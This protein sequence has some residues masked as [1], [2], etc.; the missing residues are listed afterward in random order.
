MASQT[1]L[2]I[3][4]EGSHPLQIILRERIRRLSFAKWGTWDYVW[5]VNP[6]RVARTNESTVWQSLTKSWT[7]AKEFLTHQKPRN[8]AEVESQSVWAPASFH[9]NSRDIGCSTAAQKAL[10]RVGIKHYKDVVQPSGSMVPW[11][12]WS[13]KGAANRHQRVYLRLCQNIEVP[14]FQDKETQEKIFVMQPPF[15]TGSLC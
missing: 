11:E 14:L 13:E 6:C 10:M 12:V 7:K 5:L 15:E 3:V 2:W 8:P 1:M 9:V 4:S